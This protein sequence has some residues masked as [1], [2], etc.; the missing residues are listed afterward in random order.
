MSATL[1]L[2]MNRLVSSR[3]SIPVTSSAL[4]WSKLSNIRPAPRSK[5]IENASCPILSPTRSPK[6]KRSVP[7]PPSTLTPKGAKVTSSFPAPPKIWSPRPMPGPEIVSFPIP[8]ST[9]DGPSVSKTWLKRILS[10]P[11]PARIV[12]EPELLEIVSSPSPEMMR[13]LADEVRMSS[14]PAPVRTVSPTPPRF[15]AAEKNRLS[16]SRSTNWSAKGVPKTVSLPCPPKISAPSRSE[17]RFLTR[18]KRSMK[19]SPAPAS[20]NNRRAATSGSPSLLMVRLSFPSPRSNS[21]PVGFAKTVSFPSPPITVSSALPAA[22]SIRSFPS[23][24]SRKSPLRP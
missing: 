6:I 16:P 12:S 17:P 23:P 10:S 14:S 22:T 24:P 5:V 9:D 4:V 11:S 20:T 7:S 3:I 19:S 21:R 15:P 2:K 18:P 1:R 8:P 13:S